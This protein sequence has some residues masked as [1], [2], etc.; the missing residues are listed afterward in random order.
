VLLAFVACGGSTA[1]R[2]IRRYLDL[3]AD[4]PDDTLALRA[5]I[6]KRLPAGTSADTV[7]AFLAAHGVGHD[8]LSKYYPA[9]RGE[10]GLLRVEYDSHERN[11]VATSY[12]VRFVFDST[13]RLR[14][15]R[16]ARWLTGP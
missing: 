4:T 3:S 13:A 1:Q 8:G 16:V 15:V 12:G 9:S 10:T 11:L 2:R 7:T 6:M 5:A 14:D